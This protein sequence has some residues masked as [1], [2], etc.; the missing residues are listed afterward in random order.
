MPSPKHGAGMQR[1]DFITFLGGATAWPLAAWAQQGE[2][3]RRVGVLILYPEN[4]PQS[5][6]CVTAFQEGMK[7]L[8]WTIGRNL[9]ID[10]R[11][12]ISVPASARPATT[13]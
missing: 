13:E 3:M 5:R 6:R 11:F 2:R 7:N 4:D 9:Q 8:G 12:D 10:Y 1:R